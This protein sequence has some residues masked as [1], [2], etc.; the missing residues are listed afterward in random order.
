VDAADA[1]ATGAADPTQGGGVSFRQVWYRGHVQGVGFRYAACRAAREFEVTGLARNLSDG[2][3][4]VEAE[5]A[6]P[7]LDA[8]FHELEA[9]LAV[10]IRGREARG[11]TRPRQHRGF[12]IAP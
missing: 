1:H 6:V 7:E 11:G 10:F 5:G 3:V 8:F 12:I 2:R 9:R 4:L